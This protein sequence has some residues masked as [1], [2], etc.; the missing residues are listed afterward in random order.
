MGWQ[1]KWVSSHGADFNYDFGV[2]FTPEEVAKGKINY[3]YGN[4]PLSAEEL[5]GVSVFAKDE[6]GDVFHTYST[7]GRGVEVMMGTYRM[8]DLTPKGRDEQVGRNMA[9]VRHHDRYEP[10]APR[11]TVIARPA[12]VARVTAMTDVSISRV[13][14]HDV[15]TSAGGGRAT[16]GLAAWLG[17]AAAPTFAIM[18]LWSAFFSGQ[19]D[20]LC[21]TMQGSSPMGVPL[22]ALRSSRS[23]GLTHCISPLLA[24]ATALPRYIGIS[25][26]CRQTCSSSCRRR[27][28]T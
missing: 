5:P 25:K 20:M 22:G 10:E 21:M 23:S 11:K 26:Q 7:Y 2:S 3:N 14:H 18:A 4:Q 24:L 12:R 16:P 1:F 19:P 8:L 15:D 17:L 13:L 9:W 27:S 28:R 6:T